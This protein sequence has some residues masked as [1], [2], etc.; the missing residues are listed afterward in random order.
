MK[1]YLVRMS[2]SQETAGLV[3]VSDPAQIWDVINEEFDPSECEYREIGAGGLIFARPTEQC[4]PPVHFETDWGEAT[5][6]RAWKAALGDECKWTP[7]GASVG[8]VEQVQ[9]GS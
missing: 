3:V 7:L 9:P 8:A 4:F 5:E 6:S 2:V 1:V